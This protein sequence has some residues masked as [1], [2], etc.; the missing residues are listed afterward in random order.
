MQVGTRGLSNILLI[1][2]GKNFATERDQK[3]MLDAQAIATAFQT[4]DGIEHF[5]LLDLTFLFCVVQFWFSSV[6]NHARKHRTLVF[7]R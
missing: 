7:P 3:F 4:Y 6:E 5:L 1:I 2:T